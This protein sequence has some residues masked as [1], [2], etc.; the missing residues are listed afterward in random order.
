M[1]ILVSTAI[2]LLIGSPLYGDE[3]KPPSPTPT[4]APALV[5]PAPAAAEEPAQPAATLQPAPAP[6]EDLTIEAIQNRIKQLEENKELADEVKAQALDLRKRTLTELQ[7]ATLAAQRIEKST[8]SR[9]QAPED[10]KA[11]KE[12]LA[13]NLPDPAAVIQPQLTIADLEQL[14][15]TAEQELSEAEK[16]F[17][18]AEREPKRRLERRGRIAQLITATKQTLSELDNEQAPGN[19]PEVVAAH[20]DYI[21]ARRRAAEA[22]IHALEQELL[23]YDAQND[24]LPLQKDQA[25]RTRGNAQKKV[26]LLQD[27]LLKRRRLEAENQAREA[28]RAAANAHPAV[29]LLAKD[30]SEFANKRTGQDGILHRMEE[31]AAYKELLDA[32]LGAI[33]ENYKSIREKIQAGGLTNA[34]GLRLRAQRRDLPDV[35]VHYRKMRERQ[36]SLNRTNL[37][38]LDWEDQRASL[39]DIGKR[40]EEM[41][42]SLVPMPPPEEY[43]EVESKI[44]EMLVKRRDY[45]QALIDD[46]SKYSDM[47]IKL[48]RLEQELIDLVDE[49]HGFIGEHVLW[50]RSASP[51]TF[52]E[53]S[54]VQAA[55]NWFLDRDRW[56]HVAHVATANEYLPRWAVLSFP[57]MLIAL[58]AMRKRLRHRLSDIGDKASKGTFD[59]FMPTLQAL[60]ITLVLALP[61]PAFVWFCGWLLTTSAVMADFPKAVGI[62]L[63]TV[64]VLFLAAEFFR[65]ACRPMGLAVA[66]FGWSMAPLPEIRRRVRWMLLFGLPAVFVVTL[67][68]FQTEEGFKSSLG[69][70]AFIFGLAVLSISLAVLLRPSGRIMTPILGQNAS[71]RLRKTSKLWYPLLVVLPIGLII[72]S[73]LGYHYTALQFTWRLKESLWFGL[74][75]LFAHALLLRWLLMARRRLAMRRWRERRAQQLAAQNDANAGPAMGAVGQAPEQPNLDL[76]TVHEQTQKLLHT[77]AAV[78]LVAGVCIVWADV[79]PALGI[80]N[81]VELWEVTAAAPA[82]HTQTMPVLA[83]TTGEVSN[84]E[85]AAEPKGEHDVAASPA[86]TAMRTVTLVNLLAAFGVTILAMLANKNLPGFLEIS[87]L[88]QLPI[89]N[90]A[91]YAITTI[92]RYLITIAGVVVACGQ[93][94]VNWDKVQWLLAAMSVGLGFGLQEIFANFVSGLII[95]FE[96]PIRVGDIVTIDEITGV[97][98]RIR[99]RATTITNWDRK[100]FVV[101]NREFITGRLLNWTLSDQINRIVV[102]VSVA[103]GSD[104][105]RVREL[106][107]E[108]GAS[109]PVVMKDPAPMATFEGFGDN[110]LNF[111]LRCYLPSFENRLEVINHLHMTIDQRFRE[112][113][114]RIAVPQRDIHIRTVPQ[115]IPLLNVNEAGDEATAD[116]KGERKTSAA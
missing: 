3:P 6:V 65:H 38:L 60:G 23:L 52:K 45:L 11:I 107:L 55:L 101:P 58:L 77:A 64:A 114:I 29:Q 102:N 80:L 25:T 96:R 113:N 76:A 98:S 71:S 30:N 19:A 20:G 95:L 46:Y 63:E 89:D 97:V 18:D 22:E 70:L 82:V 68:E 33:H 56:L 112:A 47:L 100:E 42:Q 17:E 54:E 44:H 92:C 73:A 86:K 74:A 109:H 111:V 41:L 31:A 13:A 43:E 15:S 51:L 26:K 32:Q 78:T 99:M 21:K 87:V 36:E 79:L 24:L 49:Y 90:G 59:A 115:S 106:L 81:K 9:K 5:L 12:Q 67:T 37:E 53:A 69:R 7:S 14:L 88:Q 91:R 34:V 85:A 10:L 1:R 62:G 35:D 110:C 39:S 103:Y 8:A 75:I 48:D 104:A 108:V 94:G 28:R 72:L 16:R 61:A 40:T 66:H 93:L 27:E 50:I 57:I 84:G 4:A 105:A 2:C 116:E 83:S